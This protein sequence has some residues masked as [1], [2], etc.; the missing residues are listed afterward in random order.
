MSPAPIRT[1]PPGAW[2]VPV[3]STPGLSVIFSLAPS[4]RTIRCP[5]TSSLSRMSLPATMVTRPSI[6]TME[7][8]LATV[9]PIRP[10]ASATMVPLL[11]TS[12]EASVNLFMPARKSWLDMVAAAA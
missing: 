12:P 7:P 9:R 11:V 2:I 5:P 6:A 10:T 8:W 1:L 4:R 3:F